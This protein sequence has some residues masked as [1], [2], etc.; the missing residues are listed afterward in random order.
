MGAKFYPSKDWRNVLSE[1][2]S[3]GY[4]VFHLFEYHAA[5][6]EI[7][8][9]TSEA[10]IYKEKDTVIFLPYFRREIDVRL[11]SRVNE[12]GLSDITGAYGY[13]G[14]AGKNF[15]RDHIYK[16]M[17]HFDSYCKSQ[18]I[19]SS[20]LR[21]HPLLINK[22]IDDLSNI[23]KVNE[24]VIVPLS[25]DIETIKNGFREGV[26]KSVKKAS[27]LGYQVKRYNA[28]PIDIFFDIYAETLRR[29]NASNF[30][31]LSKDFLSK[32]SRIE[33]IHSTYVAYLDDFPVS[34]ELVLHSR[35][36]WHSFLG[37]TLTNHLTSGVNTLIKYKIILDAAEAG[38]NTFI[39]GGGMRPGDG[40]HKYKESFAKGQN[41]N[42]YAQC[43]VHLDPVYSDLD[44][45]FQVRS[46]TLSYESNLFQRY[47]LLVERI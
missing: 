46:K 3:D 42:F 6:E 17:I 28:I 9:A 29:N 22:K 24:V 37:G 41:H 23:R 35:E 11:C 27:N 1:L 36:N 18:K 19:V 16:F 44:I 31:C 32:I 14:L 39:L 40:I 47:N 38:A 30:F 10:F 43:N 2:P 13:A 20:F 4:D 15:S 33:K 26:V 25:K 45:D 5:F 8:N 21:L 7:E 12:I 34:A